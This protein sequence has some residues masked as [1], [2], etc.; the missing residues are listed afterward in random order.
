MNYMHTFLA[1][2][3][4][5]KRK[6]WKINEDNKYQQN[7]TNNILT[8]LVLK[9]SSAATLN[10][11]SCSSYWPR[12]HMFIEMVWLFE[13]VSKHIW[14]HLLGFFFMT[15]HFFYITLIHDRDQYIFYTKHIYHHVQNK[16]CV[17]W[18]EMLIHERLVVT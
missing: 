15:L 8:T 17:S 4:S 11:V 18:Y 1:L 10:G 9:L 12:C 14:W 13:C 16:A 2:C 5:L 3:K 7:D 6:H